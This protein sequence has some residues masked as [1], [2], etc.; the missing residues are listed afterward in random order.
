MENKH[1]A[2]VG[3]GTFLDI[4]FLENISLSKSYFG[5]S[6]RNLIDVFTAS[7]V[8]TVSHMASVQIKFLE[9]DDENHSFIDTCASLGLATITISQDISLCTIFVNMGRTKHPCPWSVLEPENS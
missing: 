3:S 4:K 1:N 8:E 6:K 2:F 5:H 9:R 7:V